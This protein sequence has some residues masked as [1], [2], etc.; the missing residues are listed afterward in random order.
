M[1]RAPGMPAQSL[2]FPVAPPSVRLIQIRDLVYKVAGMFQPDSKL[3]LLE[4]GC[5]KRM[6]VLGVTTL[7]D[8]YQCLIRMPTCEAE[9]VA[10]LNEITVGETYF[11]R[12]QPQLDALRSVVFPRIVEAKSKTAN[13]HLRIWSAGCSTGEEAYTLSMVLRE[14]LDGQLQGWTFE[15][16]ATDLNQRSIVHA[17]Q[18]LYGEYSTRHLSE[19]FRR[20]YFVSSG[21]NLQINAD[22]KTFVNFSRLNFLDDAGMVL[23]AHLDVIFCCNVLIYFHGAA[24]GRVVQHFYDS[25]LPHGYL[26]LGQSE[27]LY[28]VNEDFRL[29][30]MS[31]AT[32]YV[33]SAVPPVQI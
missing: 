15:I 12:N 23:L 10:L 11:F 26:F 3:R 18:G 13:R 9:L 16:L 14:E 5:W 31:S 25:L 28:G 20:K 7:Q 19:H 21:E 33:K 29:V 2:N 30:H 1:S 22:V 8:Y 6:H 24:K 4:T 27:S 17:E 32:A